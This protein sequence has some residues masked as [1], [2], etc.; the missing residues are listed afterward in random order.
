MLKHWSYFVK[1]SSVRFWCFIDLMCVRAFLSTLQFNTPCALCPRTINR[2][3][4]HNKQFHD[5]NWLE[6]ML[7]LAP[8]SC[9][10]YRLIWSKTDRSAITNIY[11]LATAKVSLPEKVS[12]SKLEIITTTF[13]I[14]HNCK[15]PPK[16][17]TVLSFSLEV[18]CFII[19]FHVP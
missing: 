11:N 16:Y 14:E 13:S 17:Y 12:F 10:K 18:L 6:L 1:T 4:P 19:D 5:N 8:I 7:M 3:N 2:N 15:S 9:L